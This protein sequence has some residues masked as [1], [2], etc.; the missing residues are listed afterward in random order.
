MNRKE[1]RKMGMNV[2][3]Q[4][5]IG[6]D[7][8]APDVYEKVVASK[9]CKIQSEEELFGSDS[10]EV[11]RNRFSGNVY[12][13]A[14]AVAVLFVMIGTLMHFTVFNTR[15]SY[16]DKRYIYVDV[17]PSIRIYIDNDGK[18]TEIKALNADAEDIV[19]AIPDSLSESKAMEK[20]VDELTL[21]GYFE[22]NRAMLLSV[23]RELDDEYEDI[24]EGLEKY[25]GSR[26]L[27]V[28]VIA[29]RIASDDHR[30]NAIS[31]KYKI[32]Y[33]KAS[34]IEEI[35]KEDDSVTVEELA[36]LN[37]TEILDKIGSSKKIVQKMREASQEEIL[38]E[39]ASKEE[40]KDNTYDTKKDN[41]SDKKY[42][43]DKE[44]VTEESN[45]EYSETTSDNI[46]NGETTKYI[47]SVGDGSTEVMEET[48][49]AQ[50][51]GGVTDKNN[52]NNEQGE[53]VN[54]KD[55]DSDGQIGDSVTEFGYIDDGLVVVAQDGAEGELSKSY[56]LPENYDSRDKNIVSSVKNQ[57]EY[58]N[59]GSCWTFST[60]GVSEIYLAYK[61]GMN[62]NEVNLSEMQLL[63]FAYHRVPDPLGGTYG[64]YNSSETS[65]YRKL[66]GNYNLSVTSLASWMGPVD[67]SIL[68]YENI[69]NESLV[70]D[71]SIAYGNASAHLQNSRIASMED[72]DIVKTLILDEGAVQVTYKHSSVCYNSST[73]AY[74]NNNRS[75]GSNHAV[76]I[77]GW[78]DNF[79]K[80]NFKTKPEDDGAWL[81]KNSWGVNSGNNGYIWIS[82]YDASILSQAA[83][84]YEYE[85]TGN[86]DYN[87][88]YD[89]C[90]DLGNNISYNSETCYMANVFTAK[91]DEVL[92]AVSFYLLDAGMDYEI[93]VYKELSDNTNP[94]SGTP[95]FETVQKGSEILQG[96]YTV[97]LDKEVELKAGEKYS[98][99]VKLIAEGRIAMAP[100]ET[101]EKVGYTTTA[102]SE[103]GQ[104]FTSNSGTEWTDRGSKGNVRIK[105]FTNEQEEVVVE[106]RIERYPDKMTYKKDEPID[107]TG[108]K[109]RIIYST[110]RYEI[111][112]M[113]EFKVE[114]FDSSVPGSKEIS[115]VV[116]NGTVLQMCTVVEESIVKVKASVTQNKSGHVVISWNEAEDAT[117]Y[118]V[119]RRSADEKYKVIA[120][121]TGK[122]QYTDKK[123]TIGKKYNYYVIPYRTTNSNQYMAMNSNVCSI[124]VKLNTTELLSKERLKNTI[125]IKW[126]GVKAASGYVIYRSNGKNG[127]YTKIA[128][129]NGNV[130]RYKDTKIVKDKKYTYKIK[131]FC[132]VDGKMVYSKF[133]NVK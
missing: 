62:V 41:V 39:N 93:Q 42:S 31:K 43:E 73:Y 87:Y 10:T 118:K 38:S 127:K 70:V 96:Y 82:Y 125:T 92:K 9:Q 69:A 122:Y 105:A 48:T 129:V 117:G 59:M 27:D 120:K 75:K 94:T 57:D 79:S 3:E 21:Q 16:E 89:G 110:G 131:A 36:G 7:N 23:N 115:I 106:Y 85:S 81:V 109:V 133:S 99:V 132:E 40:D 77:V 60:M 95:Q 4:L 91:N 6:L 88:Q 103:E 123:V 5:A 44:D 124:T 83:Y 35:S 2:K 50:P 98:V 63:Y 113:A 58:G 66:G 65:D 108:G 72:I 68:G 47:S 1:V 54:D 46:E 126:S 13:Y 61:L 29:R 25:I 119:Y 30:A 101:S 102:Y 100:V 130:R 49:S 71:E 37:I 15:S 116:N 34:F 104:S 22:N 12:R 76:T 111:K 78:D 56:D 8:M 55:D 14:F 64:D 52:G 107:L 74:Y 121:V 97:K 67:E 45:A 18:A 51:D 80:D 24:I 20:L 33:G 90:A 53:A 19:K 114:G 128:T 17:N 32:S 112:D 86:Y 26:K 11:H 28:K 84:T